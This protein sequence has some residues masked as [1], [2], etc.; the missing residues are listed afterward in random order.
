MH[1]ILYLHVNFGCIFIILIRPALVQQKMRYTIADRES[2]YSFSDC[3]HRPQ[4]FLCLK[5]SATTTVIK[6]LVGLHPPLPSLWNPVLHL[7][8]PVVHSEYAA[9]HSKFDLHFS[10]MTLF[11]ISKDKF[12][13][14]SLR[15]CWMNISLN[16]RS[17]KGSQVIGK[18]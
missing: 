8:P 18:K 9:W 13:K 1:W 10:L 14:H 5:R 7:Q 11:K 12:S 15:V 3:D 16:L 6:V 17:Y 4:Y 2:S